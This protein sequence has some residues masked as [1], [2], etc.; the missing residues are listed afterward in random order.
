MELDNSGSENFLLLFQNVPI[1]PGGQK[2]TNCAPLESFGDLKLNSQMEK[3][4]LKIP[5][6]SS[7]LWASI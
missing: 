2:V 1:S 3:C 5:S 7:D 4:Q 6:Y